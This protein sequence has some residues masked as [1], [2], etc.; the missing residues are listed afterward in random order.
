MQPSKRSLIYLIKPDTEEEITTEVVVMEE[1]ICTI[2]GEKGHL[3]CS[4]QNINKLGTKKLLSDKIEEK[5]NWVKNF[6]EEK[7]KNKD[8]IYKYM[9]APNGSVKIKIFTESIVYCPCDPI[10]GDNGIKKYYGS[11]T[12]IMNVDP[13]HITP[14]G[15]FVD[16][17]LYRFEK[18]YMENGGGYDLDGKYKKNTKKVISAKLVNDVGNPLRLR[19]LFEFK[20]RNFQC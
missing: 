20:P 11:K 19:D 8:Y 7:E 10:S 6:E 16:L 17:E 9:N 1:E 18:N 3:A 15:S 13:N 5:N 4:C 12:I 14:D 2:C